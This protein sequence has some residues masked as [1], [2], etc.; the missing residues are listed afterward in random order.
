MHDFTHLYQE[1]KPVVFRYLYY[2][3]GDVQL[4][5]DLTQ[6]T[7]YQAYLSL[8][9]FQGKSTIS[10]WIVAIARNVYLK[11][12]R[13]EKK[14]ATEELDWD[15]QVAPTSELPETAVVRKEFNKNIQ[16]ILLLL[17]ENYR[18]VIIWREI[19]GRS[20][21]EIGTIMNK[22]PATVRVI[23]FRAK[24]RFRELYTKKYGE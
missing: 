2:L 5:E 21:E 11:K 14:Y 15:S 4:A 17:P 9:R 19:E 12:Y 13:D 8:K 18:S 22:S 6:E 20:F 10:T 23:L 3:C 1:L 7:F 16:N 24:K